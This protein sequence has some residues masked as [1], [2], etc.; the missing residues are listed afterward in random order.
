MDISKNIAVDIRNL[1]TSE[2][3]GIGYYT[4]QVL[5]RL[6][7][8]DNSTIYKLFYNGFA[9]KEF[10][11]LHFLNAEMVQ[12]RYPNK[13]LNLLFKI[14]QWPK[15]EHFIPNTKTLFLPNWNL[16][17]ISKSVR[18]VLTVHDLSPILM[19]EMYGWKSR[20]WHKLINIPNL[21][22]RADKLIAVSNFTKV[23]LEQKL[24]IDAKKIVVAPLG[25]DTARFHQNIEVDILRS[26]RNKYNLPG[27]FILFLGTV[28]P[29]KNL[30]RIL[31]AFEL[32]GDPVHLVIAGQLGWK[33]KK[34]LTQIYN[35][36]KKTFIHFLGYVK[37]E[38]KPALMKLAEVFLWPSLYEG[39]GLPLLESM[40]VGT[41]VITSSV[42]SIPEVV[43]D[44]AMLIDPYK[45]EAITEGLQ[46]LLNSNEL[47]DYYIGK[48][49]LRVQ[50][51]SWDKHV[52]IIHS[53]LHENR[54]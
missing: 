53:Q 40:A 20:I 29:R 34:V 28:E 33:Y 27:R 6:I 49:L 2:I 19:P 5:E 47:K 44:S 30:H 35:S 36:K 45:V 43:G 46:T 24:Q 37:E 7:N 12:T 26:V 25:V 31:E 13:I 8:Q 51:F 14:F 52:Q 23:S 22:K 18:L 48:G 1:H 9:K 50:N 54:V 16:L 21:L 15:I 42:A 3:S 38:D 39:F 4:L 10:P 11:T 17:P 32:L 41:P